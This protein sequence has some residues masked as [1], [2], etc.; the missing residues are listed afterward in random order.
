MYTVHWDSCI[1][2]FHRTDHALQFGDVVYQTTGINDHR[3]IS[4]QRKRV[5]ITVDI[6]GEI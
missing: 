6:D 2:T 3:W 1:I 5:V 4:K